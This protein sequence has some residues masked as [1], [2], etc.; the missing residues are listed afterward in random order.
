MGCGVRG[1]IASR[2][3]TE[4]TCA[5]AQVFKSTLRRPCADLAHAYGGA[6]GGR[7]RR[8]CGRARRRPRPSASWRTAAL[9][10]SAEVSLTTRRALAERGDLGQVGDAQHLPALGEIAQTLAHR[11]GGMAAD[12]G[13]DLVEHQRRLPAMTV[14]AWP[15]VSSASITRESSPPDPISRSGPAGTPGFGAIRNSTA[16]PPV[17]PGSRAA[18]RPRRWRP[19]SPA[20]LAAPHRQPRRRRACSRPRAAPRR[21]L[22]SS[23]CAFCKRAGPANSTSAPPRA[24]RA[25]HAHCGVLEH[26]CQR[27]AVLAYR[28]GRALR[29]AL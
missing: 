9:A 6:V 15:A 3:T 27:P 2:V 20:P 22:A 17:G 28:A 11:A 25:A 23:A 29:G 1:H 4:P 19:P 12:P 26:A 7:R 14:R 8:A 10:R 24:R 18:S 16:S 5:P 21:A 13:V